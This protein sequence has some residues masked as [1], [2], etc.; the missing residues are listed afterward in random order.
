M[1]V[2]H[3]GPH[4]YTGE[5]VA[6]ISCHGNPLLVDAVMEVIRSTGLA[7]TAENGEFTKRAYI[8]GK[9]DLAQAEAVGALINAESTCGIHMAQSLLSGDLSRR[10]CRM[11]DDLIGLISGI[12]ASFIV[13]D[14]DCDH[15]SLFP[16]VDAVIREIDALLAHAASAP[17]RYSGIITTIAGLPNAGKSSLFNA[18]LGYPRAIVHQESGTTR[19]VIR[20]HLTFSGIDFLFHD[21]A[22]IRQSA[23]GPE[24][25]GVRKTID[26]LK[27][28]HLVL[29][30]VDAC[31]GLSDQEKQWLSMGEKTIVVMNKADLLHQP[32]Y[33]AQQDTVWV[34]AKYGRG[35]HELTNAMVDRFPMGHQEVF[36]SRH[37]YLLSRAREYLSHC[38]VAI[39]EGM[40]PDVLAMDL[41]TAQQSIQE[42][43][44]GSI[45]QDVLERIFSDFCVGK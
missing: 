26:V 11:G 24:E 7:R 10:V 39:E 44:G 36:I 25:I 21:T 2:F 34:S 22:G 33:G 6:E 38:L 1:V 12:E 40:T 14:A 16:A 30:V 5:D 35:I 32:H 18:V 29:Y 13:D 28:S 17:K 3:P 41:K 37:T 19:D 31:R 8:N 23:S 4:S 27:Q 45:G 43:T 42:I 9:M 15:G 20:E